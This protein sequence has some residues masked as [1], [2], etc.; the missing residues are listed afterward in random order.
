MNA[1]S[2]DTSSRNVQIWRKAKIRNSLRLKKRRG[3]YA[4][5]VNFDD[6][7]S[8]RKAYHELLLNALILSKAYKNLRRDFKNL[9]LEK[10]FQDQVD[11]SLNESAQAVKLVKLLKK[12]SPSY[13]LR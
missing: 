5:V 8:L 13:A 7:K 12:K 6:P 2:L 10:T 3:L 4:Y 1:Q 11:G 9:K